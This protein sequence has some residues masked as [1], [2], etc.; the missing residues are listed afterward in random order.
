MS[1]NLRGF[2]EIL[3]QFEYNQ[4]RMT[5]LPPAKPPADSPR[6]PGA[7]TVNVT[8]ARLLT[9]LA[10]VVGVGLVV[11]IA[12]SVLVVA[13]VAALPPPVPVETSLFSLSFSDITR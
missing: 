12:G 2:D 7:A 1:T 9:G 6:A 13:P 5:R 10:L 3:S 11:R 4:S 8:H